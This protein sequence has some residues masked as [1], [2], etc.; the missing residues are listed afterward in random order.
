MMNIGTIQAALVL[1]AACWLSYSNSL[2]NEFMIDDFGLILEKKSIHNPSNLADSFF[3]G[4][5]FY[6]SKQAHFRPVTHVFRA[7]LYY[8]F[9]DNV[10][11]Y[12]FTNIMLLWG[13]GWLL[14]VFLKRLTK[15]LDIAFL[16]S[17][18]FCIH[19]INNMP[20]NYITAHEVMIYGILSVSGFLLFMLY[21]EKQK[22]FYYFLSVVCGF[23]ALLTQEIMVLFPLYIFLILF[24]HYRQSWLQS[25]KQCLPYIMITLGYVLFRWQFAGIQQNIISN[26]TIGEIGWLSYIVSVGNL[27]AWCAWRF[28]WPNDIIFLWS[29][30]PVKDY[31]ISQAML[32]FMLSGGIAVLIYRWGYNLKAMALVWF[33]AGFLP[34]FGIC[35]IYPA[36]G[37]IIEPHWFFV[38]SIG[39]FFLLAKAL[40]TLKKFVRPVVWFLLMGV[41]CA[42]LIYKTR[43]YNVL[44]Q[45]QKS[46]CLYWLTHK[47]DNHGP[48]FWLGHAYMQEK[49]YSQAR[50]YF[51]RALTGTFMDWQVYNNFGL[52]AMDEGYDMTAVDYFNKA[53][54][55]NPESAVVYNNAGTHFLK[56]HDLVRAEEC[57][58]KTIELSR[59]EIEPRLNLIK[60]YQLRDFQHKIGPLI[61]EILQISPYH[62]Q[63]LLFF[64]DYY[65]KEGQI[66]E[67]KKLI[68]HMMKNVKNASD[69]IAFASVLAQQGRLAEAFDMYMKSFDY[70]RKN[71][72]FYMEFGKFLGNLGRFDDAIQTWE[73]GRRLFPQET[74]FQLLIN[75]AKKL[76]Y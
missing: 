26:I 71:R 29:I 12:R 20:I 76:Q 68:A 41:V 1:F 61:K 37:L 46:Y 57:F 47:P 48:N 9:R 2:H 25:L 5:V 56:K 35:F 28:I 64:L 55:V 72:L 30:A 4:G 65:Q 49:N 11:G 23:L 75:Q 50:I 18:L 15:R 39:Y 27:I 66:D 33:A 59:F 31:L 43:T 74:E 60:I 8:F 36:M 21:F 40:L 70:D 17:L 54:F 67:L 69:L 19:P 32:L 63:A 7:G 53:L 6:K 73:D 14:F 24:F 44:F 22:R 62:R 52:M 34:V 51:D 45:S 13:F 3:D 42:L 10:F 58:L 38:S 16:G